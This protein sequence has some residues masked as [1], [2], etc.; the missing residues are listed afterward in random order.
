MTASCPNPCARR[1]PRSVY[2]HTSTGNAGTATFAARVKFGTGW[3]IYENV[4]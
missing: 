3:N 1:T 2:L 4:L